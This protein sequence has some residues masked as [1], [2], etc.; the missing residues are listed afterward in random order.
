M[1]YLGRISL[2]WPKYACLDRSSLHLCAKWLDPFNPRCPGVWSFRSLVTLITPIEM[3]LDFATRRTIFLPLIV[4]NTEVSLNARILGLQHRSHH[5]PSPNLKSLVLFWSFYQARNLN[6]LVCECIGSYFWLA[7]PFMDSFTDWNETTV[8]MNLSM[9]R[10]W[11]CCEI[12]SL[13]KGKKRDLS[14]WDVEPI[15]YY[16]IHLSGTWFAQGIL[17]PSSR[18]HM[19]WKIEPVVDKDITKTRLIS[20]SQSD[21]IEEEGEEGR[22]RWGTE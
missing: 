17:V 22:R 10:T 12:A 15:Q 13:R 1:E 20:Y 2:G 8:V 11:K 4:F 3:N 18:R 16:T 6:V 9:L 19:L 5:P 14:L 21:E 7:D